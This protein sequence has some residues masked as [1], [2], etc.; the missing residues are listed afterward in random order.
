MYYHDIAKYLNHLAPELISKLE[1]EYKL[2]K[3]YRYFSCDFV[4][5]ISYF[6]A[7][8]QLCVLRCKVVPS[9]RVTSKPYDVWT[10]LRKN[11]PEIPGGEIINHIVG[12]LFRIESAVTTGVT[13][14]SK[15]SLPCQWTVPSG[16]KIDLKPTMAE[17]LFFSKQKYTTNT[18]DKITKQKEA[19][20]KFKNY[21]PSL[22]K[23]HTNQIKN[24]PEM[25]NSLFSLIKPDI[26]QSCLAE[27]MEGKGVQESTLNPTIP[28]PLPLLV[29]KAATGKDLTSVMPGSIKLS[30]T[31]CKLIEENTRDQ[32]LNPVW[33][34]QRKGRLTASKF[35]R[36]CTRT[37][38]LSKRPGNTNILIKDIMDYNTKCSTYAM[39]H[40]L[41]M[42]PHAKRKLLDV[43]T[44]IYKHK[45]V[46]RNEV[47]LFVHKDTPHLGASP[48]L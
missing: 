12:M 34:E 20:I 36:V 29:Q 23:T 46:S 4:R 3:A 17:E 41:A 16:Q 42:E 15:T 32:S 8:P 26:K 35:Y 19:K 1:S 11:T 6:D 21:K 31:D 25:R 48:D 40:G 30:D 10:I 24:K 14:P 37:N 43:F 33:Y 5:E 18:R 44:T 9:H 39:K 45:K 13:N 27:M 7:S 38:T 47:G 28:P 2:G 22:Y